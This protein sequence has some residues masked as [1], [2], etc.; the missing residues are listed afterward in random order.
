MT[1]TTMAES[2]YIWSTLA[3]NPT[4][5]LW[6]VLAVTGLSLFLSKRINKDD[7]DKSN[8]PWAPGAVPILGHALEYRKDPSGFLLRSSQSVG[9]VF[10]LNLAGKHMYVVCG[11]KEQKF[12]ANMPESKLSARKAVAEI[13]FEQTLG[14]LNVHQ[15]TDIHKGI[16]KGIWHSP[17]NNNKTK[18]NQ[19]AKWMTSI[20]RAMTEE[21]PTRQQD[22]LQWIRRIMLRV[23]IEQMIGTAFLDQWDENKTGGISFLD[24][25]MS[26]QD[27]LED[28]TAKSVVLP[29][30]LALLTMLWPL[31]KRRE[32]FQSTIATHL[33][34]ILS[35]HAND[36]RDE[37]YLGFWLNALLSEYSVDDIS[38][39]IIGLLFAAHKNPAIGTAQAFLIFQEQ[40]NGE[41]IDGVLL[42]ES[43]QLVE[44]PDWSTLQ[45]CDR[46]R[47]WCLETLR[48]TAH[49]IGG[50][51]TAQHDI[52]IGDT[53][54]IIPK[55]GSVGFSH[56]V[57]N[58][59]P[60]NWPSAS[61]F[62]FGHSESLYQDEYR[63][64][65]FSHGVHKC[66]GQQLALVLLQCTLASLLTSYDVSLP[67]AIPP[68][69]FERATL[70]QREAP[71]MVTIRKRDQA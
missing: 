37:Q 29:K 16:I 63:F 22:F 31:Q 47:R 17:S 59:N 71:V 51:R 7:D 57:P 45:S 32:R 12:L 41:T 15:G 53:N 20:Q 61:E 27:A 67:E 13:G 38:E 55:G 1:V 62:S 66:P 70:A 60:D 28:V 58:I 65:T 54:Y 4:I 3:S 18:S 2:E 34:S 40:C 9:S 69:S 36:H 14:T 6:T 26:F 44:T 35:K 21:L 11:P 46:L 19:V 43:K 42:K 48:V 10:Q 30:W 23:T 64:T 5:Y 68:L 52:P 49:S 50:V 56:I 25:F 24:E 33:T 8:I 39:F